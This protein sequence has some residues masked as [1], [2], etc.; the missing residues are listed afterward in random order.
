MSFPAWR[1]PSPRKLVPP[2]W[3]MT[4]SLLLIFSLA[5][6]LPGF[7]RPTAAPAAT[8]TPES[9]LP[10]AALP[11]ALIESDPL[12]NSLFTTATGITLYFS[13][14]I[15]RASL[16]NGLQLE[17]PL[18]GRFTWRD[19]ATVNFTPTQPLPEATE[20]KLT[21]P[22]SIQ[23]KNG[24]VMGEPLELTFH[25]PAA[26]RLTE[27]LPK[28][29]ATE[30]D[31]STAV[32]VSFNQPVAPLGAEQ[33]ET[34]PAFT[35]EPLANGRGLWLNTSTYVFYPD[36]PLQGGARYALTLNPSLTSQAGAGL[37]AEESQPRRW[38]FTTAAPRLDTLEPDPEKPLALDAAF[39]LTFNQPMDP[40]SVEQNLSL[41]D[42]AGKPV[43]GSYRWEDNDTRLIFQPNDLLE[44]S[45]AYALA[46]SGQAR[47][48]G[49]TLLADGFQAHYITMPPLAVL[50]TTPP[51]GQPLNIY[52]GY[53]S[54]VV[55]FNAPLAKQDLSSL[56]R[57]SPEIISPS[58]Y[59]DSDQK[60]VYISG[61]FQ[62]AVYYTLSF[63]PE[64]RDRWGKTAGQPIVLRFLTSPAL[65]Q[66]SVPMLQV[67][68]PS[69]FLLPDH[70][71]LQAQATNI[72]TLRITSSQ[73]TLNEFIRLAENPIEIST[74]IP[75]RSQST[76]LQRLSLTPN[77][78][79]TVQIPLSP[80]GSTLPPG[81]YYFQMQSPELKNEGSY[82][83]TSF[84]TVVSPIQ[85]T[86]KRSA[87][88]AAVWAVDLR[89]NQPLGGS[90]ITFYD[91]KLS[92]LGSCT[93][94]SLG[95]CQVDL[96]LM[97]DNY[98]Q[99]FAVTGQPAED[100]FSL[101]VDSWSTGVAGWNFGINT[102]L[103]RPQPF[104]Y[105]YTDRPIYRPGQTVNFRALVRQENN[106][107]YSPPPVDQISLTVYGDFSFEAGQRPVITTLSLPLSSY[108]SAAGSFTLPVDAQPGLYTLQ[109]ED[110]IYAQIHFRVAE[111]RK[112]EIDLQAHF[113]QAEWQAEQDLQATIN[114][115][116]YFG[117]PASN[118]R[119]H[120]ALYAAPDD[121]FLPSDFTTGR[122]SL[123]WY[124]SGQ[125]F[126][127]AFGPGLLV[128]EGDG[129]VGPD[130]A[131]SLRI[132]ADDLQEQFD[133]QARQRL[134]L[135]VTFQEEDQ[136]PI[137]ARDQ[138][139][140]HP[141]R[142]YIGVRQESWM[143]QAETEL[144][145][146][147]QTVDTHGGPSGDHALKAV[148][149]K[150]E[151]KPAGGM[152]W[153]FDEPKLEAIYT[154]IASTDFQTDAKG[155]ARLAFTP[156]EP[157]SYQLEVSGDNA[158]T[159]IITW[160]GGAG[161]AAW[162]ALPNQQ[163]PLTA[164]AGAY[165][166]GDTARILIPNPFPSRAIAWVTVERSRIMRSQVI[167]LTDSSYELALP[168]S[169]ED[170]PNIYVSVTLLGRTNAGGP[171]F[172]QGYMQLKIEPVAQTLKVDLVAQ[173]R[174]SQPGGE[175]R[176]TLRVSDAQGQPVQGEFSLALVDKA[177]LA[178]ADPNSPGIEEA[179]YGLQPLGVVSS[180][181]LAAFAGRINLL[182]PVGGGGGGDIGLPFALRER[183]A[184]TAYWNG[185]IETD[186]SGLA[187]ISLTLPDDLT[188]WVADL[189][190][191]TSDTKVGEASE[192][193]IAS[194]DL[195]IRPISPRFFVA[196]DHVQLSATIH[197][198]T[199]QE[200]A[201][202]VR[203]DVQGLTLDDPAQAQQAVNIPGNGRQ[204]VSWWVTAQE[205]DQAE[206]IF[207]ARAGD[208]QDAA[209]P[210][211]GLLPVLRYSTPQ[212]FATTGI[213]SEGGE[214]L[215]V[216]G[217]PRSFTP[218]GGEFRLEMSPSLA[219]A[220]LSGLEALETF[221]L[222]FTE[223]LL[224]RLLPNVVTYRALQELG[225]QSPTL[226]P[227]LEKAI[228]DSLARL[229]Q[230]QN[231]DGG[232]GWAPGQPSD[233]YISAYVLF[234]LSQ[235]YQT[236]IFLEPIA[237]QRG[238]EYLNHALASAKTVNQPWQL[239]RLVFQQFVLQQSGQGGLDAGR[240]YEQRSQLNPW[241]KALLAWMLQ[242]QS[243][244]D[245]RARSLFSELQSG[246]LR[247][248]SG[249]H[250][251]EQ[252]PS[253]SNLGSPNFTTA[254]VV[255]I[256]ARSDPASPLLSEAVRYLVAHRRASGSWNSSYDTAWVLLALT[257]VLKG[258]GE[259]QASYAFS[260]SLNNEPLVSGQ[261]GGVN[262]LT[263]VQAVA[264]LEKLLANSPNALRINREAGR[265]RLY[266][267]AFLQIYRPVDDLPPLQRGLTLTRSY[268]LA[269]QDCRQ[270]AC[271][272][273]T[274]V[275]LADTAPVVL[276][277]LSLT[278][279]QAMQYLVVE[280]IIPAG[281]EILD[282]QLK[283]TQQGMAQ[284]TLPYDPHDPFG[285]GWGWW[286]F[287]PPQIY[288]NRIRWVARQIPA[289]S[290][291]LTYR[292]LPLQVGNYRLIPAHAYQ[293]YFPEVEA[294]SAGGILEIRPQ[295]R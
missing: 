295:A 166:P 143:G 184:D 38:S 150:V 278:L 45:T 241:S 181:S 10:Q 2:R 171:D 201:V 58:Y 132:P 155:R 101:A 165:Q 111:Y 96:P 288:S 237:L 270:Q 124:N 190:G 86:L 85:L 53:T 197:N 106:G 178:L 11:P 69:L 218:T 152:Q 78:S 245:E 115:S 118:I 266:Y 185:A 138:A 60:T 8:P 24:L 226:K 64:L 57:S 208:L 169:E 36:P 66:L 93:T 7:L 176:F 253:T 188:T 210:E 25:T 282:T 139:I 46:L 87:S 56:I 183:F 258:T 125:W 272:P 81:L 117:A 9:P 235:A 39:I 142:F 227:R 209:R 285:L 279:P 95:V 76:W 198:N 13:Q 47:A 269:G 220:I 267:R 82:A 211:G 146:T 17:P 199:T 291:E 129:Q 225:L 126:M 52:T 284:D 186:A 216:I 104:I 167:E 80:N 116:Y 147:I 252:F 49:G 276:V 43:N 91:G 88:Q 98:T 251:E 281:A 204:R 156:P 177:L 1:A 61:F 262:N 23:A 15:D 22:A 127:L 187:Q 164:D 137:S 67:G 249:A 232:W 280:D 229:L 102:Q 230:S 55:E 289:G 97:K 131:Y 261:A 28:A 221:P 74:T 268:Y 136:A 223:P 94:D 179:F 128:A 194:K 160:V 202:N 109:A 250:W 257:E 133:P 54:F 112:P 14:A 29:D 200:L 222:D 110:N 140:Y 182:P 79:Q 114:A 195:L 158:V 63:S 290:Y 259:L 130:G 65:P 180:L 294:S 240:F 274:S 239:D 31:P 273:I 16:E 92:T 18:E 40:A 35:L 75:G 21:L 238:W 170:A 271:P 113:N 6:S 33:A 135:E 51:P 68:T 286:Y 260:A 157:G 174:R 242:A 246:A 119:F 214:R 42:P 172:R 148:F 120:W 219:A 62:P 108:G 89:S 105:L 275:Q 213:L 293:Y 233:G 5:C 153:G 34:P 231:Q 32:A 163:L 244:A 4:I 207:S 151:W 161:A 122:R 121:L 134:T 193:I 217:L 224:S 44:R 277:R 234:G 287:N 243:P 37:A 206:L 71:Q 189:R 215:E 12:P 30:V 70:A 59:L 263:P 254:V 83:P 191:V 141:E 20:V 248:A 173:P 145:F 72:S 175:V 255:Y 48:R 26:L 264:P 212:T 154:F 203:L 19:E 107:R 123:D 236:G 84:L 168:L 144:G 205:V 283:T 162:P 41:Q 77:R 265:G 50:N 99:L 292:L 256:L 149:Q 27:S 90:P 228:Q 192:E 103:Y 159:Q 3:S 100:T 73:L 196:G 247:S